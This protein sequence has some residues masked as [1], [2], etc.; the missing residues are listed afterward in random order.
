MKVLKFAAVLLLAVGMFS[1]TAIAQ[2][3]E[4]T[5]MTAIPVPGPLAPCT[6]LTPTGPL[7]GAA[8]CG[9]TGPIGGGGVFDQWVSFMA[10]ATAH[11]VTTNIGSTGTDSNFVV[12][13]ACPPVGNKIGC[14]EDIV[15]G[16]PVSNYLSDT[17]VG[18][19]MIGATYYVQVG[20]Y[21]DGCYGACNGNYA[22]TIGAATG[23]VCGDG[24]IS[25]VPAGNPGAEE[26]EPPGP[27]CSAT[28]Q[29]IFVCGDNVKCGTEQCDGTDDLACPG[30]CAANCTCNLPKCGDNIVHPGLGEE[31]DGTGLPLCPS[32]EYCA[33]NCQCLEGIPAVSEWGLAVLTLIGLVSGTILFGRRRVA[34]S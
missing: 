20:V 10:T 28:C 9:G 16:P 14:A 7:S 26:C 31:C 22:V 33:T 2:L 21:C 29:N 24:I 3:P 32:G 1:T 25:C 8:M 34:V 13:D 27:C 18:G 6:D 5:C 4:D 15:Y 11:N 17:C 23:G 12:W 19:L 30:L